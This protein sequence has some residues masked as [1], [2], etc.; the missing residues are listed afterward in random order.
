[1]A[2]PLNV[3]RE[4]AVKFGII[5]NTGQLGVDPSRIIAVARPAAPAFGV[6]RTAGAAP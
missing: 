5:C 3:R 4:D 2:G 1:M 6:C